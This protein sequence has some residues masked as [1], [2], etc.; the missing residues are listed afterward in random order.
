L[1]DNEEVT[2]RIRDLPRA[3]VVLALSLSR[4]DRYEAFNAAQLVR[5]LAIQLSLRWW[6]GQVL[7]VP[8]RAVLVYTELDHPRSLKRSLRTLAGACFAVAVGL[9]LF[10]VNKVLLL[11]PVGPVVFALGGDANDL[12]FLL[13]G[14]SVIR[15]TW[16]SYRAIT[17]YILEHRRE[18]AMLSLAG[19]PRWRLELMGASP[20]RRG[21][22]LALVQAL[23]AA[24]DAAG[25]T[26]YLVCEPTNR[27]FYR[28]AG[29]RVAPADGKVF[30]E[31][32]LM[33]RI[34][35]VQV[36]AQRKG[37]QR[38]RQAQPVGT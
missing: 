37:A 19:E 29:F 31:M 24:S 7:T 3:V 33:R 12:V 10:A 2:P 16:T 32:L 11:L 25:A 28:R 8:G 4:G 20:P 21:H 23:T 30:D 5:G 22:G 38:V 17:A 34:A 36:Y 15:L 13:V 14:I 35:P 26:V 18:A 6:L 9:V 27:E 1:F